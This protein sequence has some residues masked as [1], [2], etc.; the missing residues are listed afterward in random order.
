VL[1]GTLLAACKEVEIKPQE[2]GALTRGLRNDSDSSLS[3]WDEPENSLLPENDYVNL[4]PKPENWLKFTSL[5]SIKHETAIDPG[6][7][8]VGGDGITRYSLLIRTAGADNVSFE[9][10]RCATQEWKMY[11]TGRDD[12]AWSRVPMPSW[13]RVEQTGLNAVRYTLYKEFVCDRD[14]VV[15]K[16]SAA[17]VTKIKN[18][19]DGL[20]SKRIP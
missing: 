13:R 10:I 19:N 2:P 5:R 1:A 16:N 3:G 15:P 20:L 14:G 9:G 6:S 12:G 7:I 11:A 17:V 4:P 18:D 8:S